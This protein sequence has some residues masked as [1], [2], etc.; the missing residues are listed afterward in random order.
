MVCLVLPMFWL[1]EE[2]LEVPMFWLLEEDL[3]VP[4]FWLE[5]FLPVFWRERRL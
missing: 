1:L 2:Y 3:V 4:M 5:D